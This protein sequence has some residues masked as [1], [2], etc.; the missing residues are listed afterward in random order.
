MFE[1]GFYPKTGVHPRLREG[2]LLGNPASPRLSITAKTGKVI[3]GKRDE[4][5]FAP[6]MRQDKNESRVPMHSEQKRL[7]AITSRDKAASGE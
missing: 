7:Q 6:E 4:S 5:R 2:M 3:P 1:Q